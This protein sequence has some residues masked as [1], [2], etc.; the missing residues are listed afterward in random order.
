MALIMIYKHLSKQNQLFKIS[1]KSI[2]S[3]NHYFLPFEHKIDTNLP[4]ISCKRIFKKRD[5]PNL[6]NI[7]SS[8]LMIKKKGS[9]IF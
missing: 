2:L 7:H 6:V 8:I 4:K 3:L 9:E 5:T 1:I